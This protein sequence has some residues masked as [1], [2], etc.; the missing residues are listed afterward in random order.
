MRFHVTALPH[1]QTNKSVNACAYTQKVLN[2]ARMMMSLGHE[3]FHYGAEGSEVECTEHIQIISRAEQE[4]FFP[5]DWKRNGFQL[6][7]NAN[8]PY[9]KMT[10]MRAAAEII[11]RKQKKDFL[12]LIGGDCQKPIV[13]MVT[14]QDV[15][16]VEFGVGYYGVFARYRVFE[17][18]THQS[19]VYGKMTSDPNGQCYDA[20][21]PNYFDPEDFPLGTGQGDYLLFIGRLIGR[22][23]LAIA[24]EIAKAAD[25]KLVIAGQG[26]SIH[27]GSGDAACSCGKKIS[28]NRTMCMAC[29]EKAGLTE[30]PPNLVLHAGDNIKIQLDD[31]V[32]FVGYAD[33]AQRAKLMGDA[34]A[35]LMPTVFMEPFGG[36]AVESML[37][38]TPVLSSDW[39]AFTETI[40]HG[41]TGYRCHTLE[42]FVWA[43]KHASELDRN[44]IRQYTIANYSIDRV[45]WMY[46][47]YFEQLMGLW[48]IGWPRK[49]DARTQLDWLTRQDF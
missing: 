24:V 10:N 7:W 30:A 32:S 8:A 49:N 17:S 38:G 47:E 18:Y 21:I 4:R 1:T 48:D 15:I 12:C 41:K 46:Q 29:A 11:A 42:Q 23:G 22:K 6:E 37:V 9:W 2:F 34:T 36:V 13:D 20:V 40:Q 33:V 19:C 26:G 25:K 44:R 14:E 35:V 27:P 3:V 16:A 43:A 39:A 5:Q 31:R 28:A 45:K